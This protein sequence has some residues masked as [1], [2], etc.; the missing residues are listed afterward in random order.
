MRLFGRNRGRRPGGPPDDVVEEAEAG[1]AIA[2]ND[3]AADAGKDAA[4]SLDA[5][6]DTGVP[7]YP[8]RRVPAE[9]LVVLNANSPT[10]MAIANDYAQKRNVTN[11]L[12]IQC[13]DSATSTDNETIDLA[14]YTTYIATPISQYLTSHGNINFVVLTKGIPIRISD[15]HTGCCMNGGA[16]GQPSVDSYLAAID[17]P[18]IQGATELGITGSGTVGTGWLN[19]YWNATAPFTHA[20]FGGYLVTRL[21]GYTQAEA[22]GLVTQ[23]LSAEQGV[24]SGPAMVD[25]D[26]NHGL[27][28]KTM[29]PEPITAFDYDPTMGVTAEWDWSVWNADMLHAHDLMEA[30]GIP[31]QLYMNGTFVRGM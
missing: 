31:N 23:A 10:S 15:A 25:V 8:P 19:R 22:M 12:S 14:D 26:I 11:I 29:T 13:A 20:Q 5:T 27:G 21:D 7:P 28:D 3:T 17:Y 16:P 24:M 6:A 9:V 2:T 4:P 1:D 18:T 30:S